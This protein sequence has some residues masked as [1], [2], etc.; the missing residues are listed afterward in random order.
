MTCKVLT[1]LEE[2]YQSTLLSRNTLFFPVDNDYLPSLLVIRGQRKRVDTFFLLRRQTYPRG[3]VVSLSKNVLH[4]RAKTK[5]KEVGDN[6][7]TV[8]RSI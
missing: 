1:P 5:W 7:W 4:I 8:N 6:S 2:L 3:I